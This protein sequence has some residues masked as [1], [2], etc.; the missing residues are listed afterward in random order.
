VSC[1]VTFAYAAS[2]RPIELIPTAQMQ[3]FQ[4]VSCGST[5][6]MSKRSGSSSSRQLRML[7]AARSPADAEDGFDLRIRERLAQRASP[8]HPRGAKKNELH[9]R[10]KDASGR[11]EADALLH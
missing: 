4:P 3:A 11:A 2:S 8:D 9:V 1:S 5:P 6:A 7:H 10:R